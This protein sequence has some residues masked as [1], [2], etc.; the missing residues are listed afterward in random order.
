MKKLNPLAKSKGSKISK[1]KKREQV[2]QLIQLVA[3]LS[4]II[5]VAPRIVDFITKT[6]KDIAK[7]I[8]VGD[9]CPKGEEDVD[10]HYVNR[11]LKFTDPRGGD[12]SAF[13]AICIE[14]KFES[15]CKNARVDSVWCLK[16]KAKGDWFCEFDAQTKKGYKV[17][18]ESVE[19]KSVGD[20]ECTPCSLT[21]KVT[22][23]DTPLSTDDTS[24][25]NILELLTNLE[26]TFKASFGTVSEIIPYAVLT[27]GGIA[28]LQPVFEGLV[29]NKPSK[30]K[31][32]TK[33][34]KS[35]NRKKKTDSAD[36][37]IFSGILSTLGIEPKYDRKKKKLAKES[38]SR[39]KSKSKSKSKAKSR[40]KAMSLDYSSDELDTDE[41][42]DRFI[43][44]LFSM[45]S[46]SSDGS[47]FL[48][49]TSRSSSR[50]RR[51]RKL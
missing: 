40:S 13:P 16:R 48:S 3:I 50:G 47:D 6:T 34:E 45:D 49:E 44:D 26:D 15:T 36:E 20:I 12:R 28:L 2:V 1:E 10:V 30:M 14:P 51:K 4:F 8:G 7:D 23:L 41:E 9:V 18:K 42:V 22:P 29:S 37:G 24:G 43:E 39:S 32:K 33:S 17:R 5:L 31:R 38:K 46:D 21:Y 11:Q 27:I 35:R 25:W 19:C